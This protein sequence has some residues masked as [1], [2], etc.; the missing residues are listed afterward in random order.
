MVNINLILDHVKARLG[1][2]HKP[3]EL[4]D[5]AIIQILQE[6]T[7]PQLSIYKPYFCQ[8]RLS[9]DNKVEGMAN[10]YFIPDEIED[11]K[12]IGVELLLPGSAGGNMQPYY[13]APLGG[14]LQSIIVGMS[15]HKL[16]SSVVSMNINPLTFTFLPPNMLRIF[17]GYGQAEMIAV[18]RTT[19]KKD[20]TTFPLGMIEDIKKL[21]FYDVALDILSIRKYFT[22]VNTNF[23]QIELDLDPL[24]VED[25]RDD[26]IEKMRTEMLRHTSQRKVFFY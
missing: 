14:D 7:L 24:N 19:H 25:K 23:A 8:Y 12:V 15:N 6:V 2:S 5:E 22:Q 11:F 10:T 3:I 18:L 20:F 4:S 1:A 26:L 9:N 13:F 16:A 21:A 17:S